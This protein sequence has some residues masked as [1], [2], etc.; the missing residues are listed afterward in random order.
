MLPAGKRKPGVFKP[1]G[2]PV[3]VNTS[4]AKQVPIRETL[5]DAFREVAILKSNKVKH[6]IYVPK[7]LVPQPANVAAMLAGDTRNN[8]I[9]LPIDIAGRF[10]DWKGGGYPMVEQERTVGELRR[11]N[12]MLQ[13]R[14]D[15][16]SEPADN[17]FDSTTDK[18]DRLAEITGK[19]NASS[20]E[21]T[22]EMKRRG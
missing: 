3:R 19:L 7:G 20:R 8:T 14:I 4:D 6:N 17:F 16:I 22:G 12:Y 13:R 11:Q 18:V 5:W 21:A 9:D 2:R 1:S 15:R 10:V